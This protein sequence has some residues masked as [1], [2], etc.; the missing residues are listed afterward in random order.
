MYIYISTQYVHTLNLYYLY[1]SNFCKEDSPAYQPV[2]LNTYVYTSLF[3]IDW[4]SQL[5]Y[6]SYITTNKQYIIK[7]NSNH[8]HTAILIWFGLYEYTHIFR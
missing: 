8:I 3:K 5:V 7:H 1:S 2:D 6:T 4:R